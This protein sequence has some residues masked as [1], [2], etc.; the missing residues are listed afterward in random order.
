MIMFQV[1]KVKVK[2]SR[3]EKKKKHTELYNRLKETIFINQSTR[4][5][6]KENYKK[7][8]T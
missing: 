4:G 8:K 5:N 6:K 2:D 3:K 7:N 1:Y